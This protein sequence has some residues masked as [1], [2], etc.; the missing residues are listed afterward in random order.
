MGSL[1]EGGVEA[2][3]SSEELSKSEGGLSKSELS[4]VASGV[5]DGLGEA[6]GISDGD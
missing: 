4:C 1:V 5:V 2:G 6:V 3:D